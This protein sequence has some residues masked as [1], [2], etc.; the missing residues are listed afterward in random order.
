MR[1][2]ATIVNILR[3]LEFKC[4]ERVLLGRNYYT[5][6]CELMLKITLNSVTNLLLLLVLL[7]PI[8]QAESGED[9]LRAFLQDLDSLTADFTQQL[10][11][12]SGELL[13]TSTGKLYMQRPGKFNWE[14]NKPYEQKIITDGE[15]LWIYDVGLE[16]VTVRDTH[17]GVQASP[18]AILGGS[19]DVDELY[20]IIELGEVEGY[21]WVRLV[22]IHENGQYNDVRL[23]FNGKK[24]GM[25]ILSDNLGQTTRIDFSNVELNADVADSRFEFT[26][27]DGVDVLDDRQ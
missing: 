1:L 26:P 4:S 16:Q 11:N 23:G 20:K 12:E 13:E 18:A 15:T 7:A 9:Q 27:P 25:M 19:V 21:D 24:L 8:A 22:P 14:Y 2:C 5:D 3:K 10:Y 6:E 17:T